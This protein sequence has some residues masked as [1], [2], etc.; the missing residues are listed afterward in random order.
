MKGSDYDLPGV[1][2]DMYFDGGRAL[3]GAYW[4]NSFGSVRSHGCVNLPLDA[5]EWLWFWVNGKKLTV[6]VH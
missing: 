3:H 5:A 4:H 1:P 6:F 2:F